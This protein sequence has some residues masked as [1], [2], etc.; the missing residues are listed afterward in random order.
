MKR[1]STEHLPAD[2][3]FHSQGESALNR[4]AHAVKAGQWHAGGRVTDVVE[5]EN[6]HVIYIGEGGLTVSTPNAGLEWS[7]AFDNLPEFDFERIYDEPVIAD[8]DDRFA[9][10]RAYGSDQTGGFVM[11]DWLEHRSGNLIMVT[12]DC[13]LVWRCTYAQYAAVEIEDTFELE[14][15]VAYEMGEFVAIGD[16]PEPVRVGLK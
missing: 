15:G 6:G 4:L 10:I 12:D 5:L 8:G 14:R 11:V 9:L 16:V 2:V 3:Q 1:S 7:I 13:L